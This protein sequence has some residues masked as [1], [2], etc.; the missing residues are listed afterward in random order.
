MLKVT[1]LCLL[2]ENRKITQQ[3][4]KKKINVDFF[5][6]VFQENGKQ[7]RMIRMKCALPA[8]EGASKGPSTVINLVKEVVSGHY[9][10]KEL[11]PIMDKMETP[12][13]WEKVVGQLKSQAHP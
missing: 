7:V 5:E 1:A 6:E 9:D 12:E 3:A 4:T 13:Y 2:G 8:P 10:R 11:F